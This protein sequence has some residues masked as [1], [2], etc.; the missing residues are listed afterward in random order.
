MKKI[1]LSAAAIM[2]FGFAS[3]AQ[4]IKF[5]AKAGLNIADFGGDAETSGSRTGFHVGVIAEFKLTEQF[6]IQPELLYSMQGAK[7]ETVIDFD[8]VEQDMKLDYLNV[9]IMA[10]YYLFEGFSIQAGPQVGFLM[11]AKAEDEDVKDSFKSIDFALNGGVGYELPLGVF[12]Q[13]RYSAGL[14]NIADGEG[15]DDYS[16]NNNVISL[17]VGYKF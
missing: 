8:I 4:D 9:P 6:S 5:G 10:K 3:Q 14:A 11:S 15:S 13:A 1:L 12:F 2:A 16:I 7:Y 17:S